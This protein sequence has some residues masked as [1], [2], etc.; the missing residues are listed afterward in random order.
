MAKND[1]FKDIFVPLLEYD[2]NPFF[3]T[4]SKPEFMVTEV[5]SVG[6][7]PLWNQ[8][9]SRKKKDFT[10]VQNHFGSKEGKVQL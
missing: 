10:F 7:N 5:N 9:S 4:L 1:W 6:A 8:C 3:F 2:I